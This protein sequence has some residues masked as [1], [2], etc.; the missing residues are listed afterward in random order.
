MLIT[1]GEEKGETS[2][3]AS[4]DFVLKPEEG[5][6]EDRTTLNT[7]FLNQLGIQPHDDISKNDMVVGGKEEGMGKLEISILMVEL[8]ANI[9]PLPTS[10][11]KAKTLSTNENQNKARSPRFIVSSP[12]REMCGPSLETE[13]ASTPLLPQKLLPEEEG[14]QVPTLKRDREPPMEHLYMAEILGNTLSCGY[15]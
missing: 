8:L 1:Q 3:P 11:S 9:D 13:Q 2:P 14:G 5:D 15:Q 6:L 10:P 12:V 4:D 7:L